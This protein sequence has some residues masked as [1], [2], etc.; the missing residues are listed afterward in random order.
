MQNRHKMLE[1]YSWRTHEARKT[2]SVVKL[3]YWH[4]LVALVNYGRMWCWVSVDVKGIPLYYGNFQVFSSE[5]LCIEPLL[6][7]FID[8]P[9]SL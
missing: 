2:I 8:E 9:E 3:Y 5:Q 4:S 1:E 7:Q 6:V